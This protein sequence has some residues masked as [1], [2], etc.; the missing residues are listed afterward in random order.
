MVLEVGA[1]GVVQIS[2]ICEAILIGLRRETDKFT[3]TV[4][5]SVLLSRQLIQKLKSARV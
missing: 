1:H 4:G 5:T 3:I 2:K